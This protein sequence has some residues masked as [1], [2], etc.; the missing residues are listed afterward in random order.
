MGNFFRS[1]F[2]SKKSPAKIKP[3]MQ[4]RRLELLGLEERVT[5]AVVSNATG[6]VTI[7]LG[8]GESITN[9]NAAYNASNQLVI[10][11]IGVS[12]TGSVT[13]VTYS[14]SANGVDDIITV[15]DATFAGGISGLSVVGNTGTESVT[16]GGAIN[17][18]INNNFPSNSLSIGSSVET[19]N[20][21]A[22]ITAKDGTS[23]TGAVTLAATAVGIGSTIN[24]TAGKI[25][26][27]GATTLTAATTLTTTGGAIAITGAVNGAFGLSTVSG[28]GAATITGI[29]GGT[30]PV[31]A[32]SIN[33]TGPIGLTAAVTAGTIATVG[34][35]AVTLGGTVTSTGPI[36]FAGAVTGTTSVNVVAGTTA[37]F[38]STV[39]TPGAISVLGLGDLT[40]TGSVGNTSATSVTAKSL[41]GDVIFGN[42]VTSS[43]LGGFI[44]EATSVTKAT[45]I[46]NLVTLAAGANA[47]VTGNL[48]S[49]NSTL[50]AI[51]TSG[52]GNITIT[53]NVD[54]SVANNNLTLT[55]GSAVTIGGNVGSSST[56]M[57]DLISTGTGLFLA[58]GNVTTHCVNVS[59]FTTSIT[60]AGDVKTN[61]VNG[62]NATAAATGTVTFAKSI[63]VTNAVADVNLTTVNGNLTV[64]GAI[65]GKEFISISS[66]SGLI[67]LGAI[68]TDQATGDIFINNKSG[69]I[70]VL[71]IIETIGSQAGITIDTD[72]GGSITTSGTINTSGIQINTDYPDITIQALASGNI[73]VGAP[74]TTTGTGYIYIGYDVGNA[75]SSANII[76]APITTSG[77]YAGDIT[78]YTGGSQVAINQPITAGTGGSVV[79]ITTNA[80]D[81]ITVNAAISA[82][83]VFDNTNSRVPSIG[84]IQLGAD[85]TTTLGEIDLRTTAIT[86][87]GPVS[88]KA[89]GTTVGDINLGS[90]EGAQNLTL[91]ATDQISLGTV[92]QTTPLNTFTV[93][94][95]RGA[96]VTGNFTAGNVVLS[97]TT[98]SIF[99]KG[100]TTITSSLSTAAKAYNIEFGDSLS[101]T[102]VLAG[103]PVFSNT[104]NL[105]F[106][107]TTSLTSGAT[108][109]GGS[110]ANV[111]LAGTIVSGGAF[112]IGAG[113]A[114]I[115]VSD[116]TQLILNSITAGS[117]F[118]SPI[119]LNAGSVGSF[120]LLGV[121]TLTLSANSTGGVTTGDTINVTNG[122]LNVTGTLGSAS[123]ITLT[124]G[125][126]TGPGGTVGN[127]TPANGTV[128][129]EG[130]LNTGTVTFN[131]ATT[132]IADVLT[133]TTATNLTGN[134]G[135]NL[136]GATLTLESVASGLSINNTFTIINNTAVSGGLSGTFAGLPEGATLSALDSLGNTITFAISYVGGIIGANDVT[137]T[138]TNVLIANPSAIPQPMVAG[139]PLLNYLT[140]VGAGEGGGPMV[141]VTLDIIPG[142]T[143][144]PTYFSFFA[145]D[146]GF[147]GGV[148]VALNEL[149]GNT[150]TKEII[151]GPGAGGG[152][153]VKVFQFNI[154]TL[155][156]NPTPVTSFFAFN[157]P[158]FSGGVYVAGGDVTGDGIGDLLVG[159]GEGGGPRVQVYAGS[160]NGVITSAPISDFFAY[161]TE[162]LGGVVVAA[163]DRT[164]D[165]TL[166]VV[167]GPASNGGYNIKSFN[168]AGTGNNPTLIENFF[169]FNDFTSIGGL[170]IATA[171]FDANPMDDL[172][173]GTTNTQFGIILNQDYEGIQ[174]NPFP[175]F[176]G[177]IRA[178][179]VSSV[180]SQTYQAVA[181]AGP[182]GGPVLS[183]FSVGANSLTQ[184]D[185]LFVLDPEFT[186]G[187]FVAN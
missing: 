144:V 151:T 186:G 185:S 172:V 157:D 2:G 22:A 24:T 85:I 118:A 7:T 110:L 66:T 121:G 184:I 40:F 183:V 155:T 14:S 103:A 36:N 107:G 127:L 106:F 88:M 75:Q 101:D 70:V 113:L 13:G 139:Q 134:S 181:A 33:S 100:N 83:S 109:T 180:L 128:D 140:A 173:I 165:T 69:N 153:N 131:A 51:T 89:Q 102:T 141:T 52:V 119:N 104:G 179:F 55:A 164:G 177:E 161:S 17:L 175:G 1:I 39:N 64:T 30:A 35:G 73:T 150:D 67:T 8:V 6:I 123:T 54:A 152:P 4:S 37:T 158:T 97:D 142:L 38:G 174:A 147:T 169:A 125:T 187:L 78:I 182:G 116:N 62:V 171:V 65:I 90:I 11:T 93:T 137:L 160:L 10:N 135:F 166:E 80:S 18:V 56:A 99:F 111:N 28:S 129:P 53:G 122:T 49:N 16:V 138:V 74:I 86:L 12:N 91:E 71:G 117:T 31:A 163:G 105:R 170:S 48:I 76:N 59:G 23:T 87:S 176:D 9:L 146:E 84:T 5:P 82:K 120:N 108:I 132:Y 154:R 72:A 156:F 46:A 15:D 25:S 45:K 26:I 19:L 167:T 162:F 136:G 98:G 168:V 178:G 57:G 149:D 21:N 92:G 124:N 27:T 81:V 133:S 145:Y 112:N 50:A 148:H 34:A 143:T 77:V 29:V 41:T 32:L 130:T 94:N 96:S 61:G 3:R 60:F 79:L 95:S 159:A 47:V 20:V 115:N 114:G 68:S 43:N 63:E 126:L 44:S 58:S 42:T